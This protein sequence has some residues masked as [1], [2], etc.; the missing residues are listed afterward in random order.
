MV[1]VSH[2]LVSPATART[3]LTEYDPL[4]DHVSPE[5]YVEDACES[6]QD[7]HDA[8]L[9]HVRAEE[10]YI[11]STLPGMMRKARDHG[12][13][14]EPLH[15]VTQILLLHLSTVLVHQVSP[16]LLRATA[17]LAEVTD[18]LEME[19]RL[20][21]AQVPDDVW[22]FYSRVLTVLR[23]CAKIKELK[24]EIQRQQRSA[25]KLRGGS[26]SPAAGVCMHMHPVLTHGLQLL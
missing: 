11:M 6:L 13:G 26:I 20:C 12:A 16:D 7:E 1:R 21:E 18:L 22:A 25:R 10:Q 24:K 3:A 19:R 2:S 4:A 17:D 14:T 5:K 15:G 9:D 8:Y 23:L